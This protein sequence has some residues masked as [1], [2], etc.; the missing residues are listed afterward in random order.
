MMCAC[1]ESVGR[2]FLAHQLGFGVELDTQRR[3][4]VMAR[5]QPKLCE[6]CRGLP[7]TP[8][9]AAA[10]HGRTS[11]IL[12]YYWREFAFETMQ[13]FDAWCQTQGTRNRTPAEDAGMKRRIE[14]EVVGELT[15]L[16]ATTPKYTYSK[17]HWREAIDKYDVDV[18]RLKGTYVANP[19]SRR[20]IILDGDGSCGVE[21][22]ARRHFHSLGYNTVFVESVPLHILFGVYMWL[23]IQ[24][25]EDSHNRIVLFG[26]RHAFDAGIQENKSRPV[27]LTISG[28][29]V[30]RADARR[31]SRS[32]CRP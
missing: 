20:A 16:H 29:K 8:H 27:S 12:R 26:D 18:V 9:P 14:Q 22:Y 28:H 7:L 3:V 2:K 30:M 17:D 25:P 21:E 15:S 13:R 4:P 23:V 1:D 32:T 11:K 31:Q 19:A 6:E 24:D 5:F 10:S